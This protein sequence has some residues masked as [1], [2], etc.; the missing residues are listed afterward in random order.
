M[1]WSASM[2]ARAAQQGR[3]VINPTHLRRSRVRVREHRG[4]GSRAPARILHPRGIAMAGW[5]PR[6]PGVSRL[7]PSWRQPSEPPARLLYRRARGSGRLY[8]AHTRSAPLQDVLSE[9]ARHRTVKSDRH[10][11]HHFS[12]VGRQRRH[13]LRGYAVL[14]AGSRVAWDGPAFALRASA[15]SRRSLGGGGRPASRGGPFPVTALFGPSTKWGCSRTGPATAPTP[16]ASRPEGSAFP[17]APLTS[18]RQ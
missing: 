4:S 10:R 7:S 17:S 12:S 14:P 1:D 15:R 9:A 5:V 13:R 18:G 3:L 16:H 2:L 8:A 6:S 11:L